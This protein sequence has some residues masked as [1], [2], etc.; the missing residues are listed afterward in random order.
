MSAVAAAP[1]PR[2]SGLPLDSDRDGIPDSMDPTPYFLGGDVQLSIER[3]ETGGQA[4]TLTW[5]SIPGSTSYV[6][7]A[8]SIGGMAWQPV[9]TN[10]APNSSGSWPVTNVWTHVPDSASPEFFRVRVDPAN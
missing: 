8:T 5:C 4:L 2:V 10:V 3:P 6:F 1:M 7:R 9:W